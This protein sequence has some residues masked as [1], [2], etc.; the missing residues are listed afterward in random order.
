[1]SCRQ[2]SDGLFLSQASCSLHL[3]NH[4]HFLPS[5]SL[6]PSHSTLI[7]SLGFTLCVSSPFLLVLLMSVLNPF[8]TENAVSEGFCGLWVES[9]ITPNLACIF[10]C[11][12]NL[13]PLF[14]TIY[15]ISHLVFPTNFNTQ[16]S[17]HV[18]SYICVCISAFPPVF[19]IFIISRRFL[20]SGN[21]DINPQ[22]PSSVSYVIVLFILP[23][24]S[25]YSWSCL[26]SADL[27]SAPLHS[28]CAWNPFWFVFYVDPSSQSKKMFIQ[29][30]YL[31]T[32]LICLQHFHCLPLAGFLCSSHLRLLV[33]A[34]CVHSCICLLGRRDGRTQHRGVIHLC[35]WV[36]GGLH[37]ALNCISKDEF[38]LAILL[39]SFIS[40][41]PYPNSEFWVHTFIF[42]IE[43]SLDTCGCPYLP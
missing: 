8:I 40:P 26:S 23:Q 11:A 21:V 7:R 34:H 15:W 5:S 32:Y 14:L 28:V 27:N 16:P 10:S 29:M 4:C 13:N 9:V 37:G 39:A 17:T 1:M 43:A 3:N 30:S 36:Q 19:L 12:W 31:K 22:S 38:T 35:L 42:L 25:L 24:K 33:I 41:V 2:E 18:L 6:W 20:L